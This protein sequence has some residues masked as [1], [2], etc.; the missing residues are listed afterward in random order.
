[1]GRMNKHQR[2]KRTIAPR[3]QKKDGDSDFELDSDSLS[4]PSSCSD[5]EGNILNILIIISMNDLLTIDS[6]LCV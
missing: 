1:M 6:L 4:N 2:K 5:N 3:K